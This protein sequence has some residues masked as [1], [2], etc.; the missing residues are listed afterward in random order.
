MTTAQIFEICPAGGLD[1]VPA[2]VAQTELARQFGL[3][4]LPARRRLV[5]YWHRDREGRLAGVW[6]AD[7]GLVPQL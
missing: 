5:C 2:P 3:D 4:Q 7:I 6:E 1:A